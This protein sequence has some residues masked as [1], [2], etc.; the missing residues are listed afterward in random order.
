MAAAPTP[1]EIFDM[2]A[3]AFKPEAAKGVEAVF[4]YSLS[5]PAGGDWNITIKDQKCEIRQGQAENP[6]TTMKL[7]DEDFVKMI[8]G[9]LNPM[10]AF[11]SGKLKIEGDMMKAQVLAQ[12][13]EAPQS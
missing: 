13:F 5:G 9:E 12:L 8:T 1:A 11:T 2:M 6:T 10:M 4:Q 7:S 3:Q